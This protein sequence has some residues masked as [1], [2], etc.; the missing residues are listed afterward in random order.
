MSNRASRSFDDITERLDEIVSSV[1]S[2]DTSLERSLDLFDEAISL[3]SEAVELVDQFELSP[4]E[5]DL[6]IAKEDA[7][8]GNEQLSE[9]DSQLTETDTLSSSDAAEEA[10]KTSHVASQATDLPA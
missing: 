7:S 10:Q 3:G 8:T 6:L 1:R 4:R 2:K 9:T 5:A